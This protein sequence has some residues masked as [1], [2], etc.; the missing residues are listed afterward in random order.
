M[1][2]DT[3]PPQWPTGAGISD[4]EAVD[5]MASLR[6]ADNA[7]TPVER[8]ASDAGDDDRPPAPKRNS[9]ESRADAEVGDAGDA[10]DA[11]GEAEEGGSETEVSEGEGEEAPDF[12]SADDKAFWAKVPPEVRPLLKKYEE[13]RVEFA[14]Q[15]AQEAAAERKKA[16]EEVQ[17]YGETHEKF[18]NWWKQNGQTFEQTFVNR[19]AAMTPDAWG[20]LS[21]ENPA[22]WARL[23]EM[24]S[25]EYQQLATVAQQAKEAERVTQERAKQQFEEVRLAEHTKLTKKLPEHF[26]TREKAAKTYDELGKFLFSKGIPAERINLIHEAPIIE[27]AL[28]AMRW[29]Q[30]QTKSPATSSGAAKTQDTPAPK[31]VTPGPAQPRG[32][33]NSEGIRQA[34]DR[35]RRSGGYDTEAA[36]ALIRLTGN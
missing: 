36:M 9:E 3:G 10:G 12:W 5:R 17:K 24:Q 33:R 26:G 19:W 2:E 22:E 27:M 7:P 23:K 29:E 14:N 11:E 25:Q 16:F 18:A 31:K 8:P 28:N 34:Q 21:Q 15:K 1:A 32:S 30:A 4:S 13:Q 35:L 6:E 20:K